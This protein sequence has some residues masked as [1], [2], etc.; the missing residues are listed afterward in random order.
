M[1]ITSVE[2]EVGCSDSLAPLMEMWRKAGVVFVSCRIPASRVAEIIW[3]QQQGLQVI[4]TALYPELSFTGAPTWSTTCTAEPA[5][6]QE[7]ALLS[8]MAEGTFGLER[9]HADPRVP[10]SVANRRY[11]GWVTSSFGHASQRLWS[12]KDETG[13]I[14]G[15]FVTQVQADGY[16]YWHLNGIAPEM[17]G[18]GVG[19]QVWRA[20]LLRSR[21]DG[22]LGVRTCVTARNLRVLRLYWGL[23]FGFAEPAMTLHAILGDIRP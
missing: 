2:V 23:G 15:F 17:Q 22:A 20:M 13:K 16:W 18:R 12:M 14:V 4:E 9:L 3:M 19:R 10:N 1:Q 8:Q 6:A 21:A 5:Q 7:V 11:G